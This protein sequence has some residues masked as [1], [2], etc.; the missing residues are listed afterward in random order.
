[1]IA[2]VMGWLNRLRMLFLGLEDRRDV[3]LLERLRCPPNTL[4][5]W[6]VVVDA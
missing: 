3:V 5:S 2:V 4:V 1:M 6:C